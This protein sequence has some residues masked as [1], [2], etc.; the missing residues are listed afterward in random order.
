MNCEVLHTYSYLYLAKI[1]Y[2]F[3]NFPEA[4]T[5]TTTC[6][7]YSHSQNLVTLKKQAEDIFSDI[8]NQLKLKVDQNV[9][10]AKSLPLNFSMD[11]NFK[12]FSESNIVPN[13][14]MYHDLQDETEFMIKTLQATKKAINV[15][16]DVLNESFLMDISKN[17]CKVLHLTPYMVK[18]SNEDFI[19][20]E[21]DSSFMS[22]S[23]SPQ[24]L[25]KML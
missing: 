3:K 5:Y 25:A 17:G 18:L 8:S 14:V 13:K 7:K 16:F 4:W 11:E 9:I 23:I 24:Q 1:E 2:L 21:K 20:I 15:K 10:F 19:T 12:D 6:I 22:C